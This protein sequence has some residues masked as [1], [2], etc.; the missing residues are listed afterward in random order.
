MTRRQAF[1]AGLLLQL[2]VLLA[3]FVPYAY[4]VQTGTIIT[5]RTVPVDPY[6]VFRGSYVQLDYDIGMNLPESPEERPV[7]VVLTGSG[8]V[9]V[10]KSISSELPDLLPGEACIKGIQNYNRVFF[11]SIAQYFA[12]ETLA[13]DLEQAR[14]AHRL[15]VDVAV[16]PSCKAVIRNITMGPEVPPEEMV[17]PWDITTFPPAERKPVP[18]ETQPATPAPVQ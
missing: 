16:K 1:L 17:N 5:L 13:R 10:R 9:F 11:P 15:F 4:H 18:G 2:I 6:S 12:E 8:D 3:L 7:Y 14:N